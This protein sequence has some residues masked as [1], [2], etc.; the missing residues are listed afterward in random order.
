MQRSAT[1]HA[2]APDHAHLLDSAIIEQPKA[3]ISYIPERLTHELA[4]RTRGNR[5]SPTDTPIPHAHRTTPLC[6]RRRPAMLA[7]KPDPIT[8]APTRRVITP[9]QKQTTPCTARP[10]RDTVREEDCTLATQSSLPRSLLLR[11]LER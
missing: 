8:T 1:A 3:S 2:A 9:T 4:G 10:A 7:P 11:L 6:A 5:T